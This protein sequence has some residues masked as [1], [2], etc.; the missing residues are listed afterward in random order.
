MN[1]YANSFGSNPISVVMDHM[2]AQIVFVGSK[3]HF[4]DCLF[5]M[6]A[7]EIDGCTALRLPTP[8]DLATGLAAGDLRPQLV[9]V[10]ES[11]WPLMD[12]DL[13]TTVRTDPQAAIAIAFRDVARISRVP[14]AQSGAPNGI[15]FLPMD[16]NIESWL[17]ILRLLLTGYPFV[18]SEIMLQ[19][20]AVTQKTM[21]PAPASP[22][23]PPV[24][25]AQPLS[26]FDKLTPR[27][28]EV[29]ALVAEGFQNKHIAEQL[30][31]SEHT[32]KL[33]L[34]HV[35]SKLGARNRTDAALRYRRHK[36]P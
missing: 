3:I 11:L 24:D 33:H 22:A 29:L 15:S 36:G 19:M 7:A 13:L 31:L 28:N 23:A 17:T 8:A 1:N 21:P 2:L 5:R 10:D 32:V 25:P 16:L 30:A 6:I 35:I 27:E 9:I 14:L 20:E 26:A 4:P 34:H 18:P 12:A